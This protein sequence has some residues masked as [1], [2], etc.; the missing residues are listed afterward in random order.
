MDSSSRVMRNFIAK[1][2]REKFRALIDGLSSGRSG[3]SLATEFGVSRER[4]RQW[5]TL[6][7]SAIVVYIPKPEARRHLN[8]YQRKA[9]RSEGATVSDTV[10][11]E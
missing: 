7:G 3:P 8:G 5:K 6:F 10:R 4:I 9:P 1:Y 2:G 11:V